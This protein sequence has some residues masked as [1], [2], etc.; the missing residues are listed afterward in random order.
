MDDLCS[1]AMSK[2]LKRTVDPID[3]I[4]A[5]GRREPEE[6]RAVIRAHDEATA[7]RK[8]ILEARRYGEEMREERA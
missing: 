8:L 2:R 3:P 7:R 4:I 5:W 6:A 1:P